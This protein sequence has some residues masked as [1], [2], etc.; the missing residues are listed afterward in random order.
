MDHEALMRR[1]LTLAARGRGWVSPNPMVGAV[2]A[3]NGTVIGEGW[4]ERCGAPHA[5]RNALASCDDARGAALYVTLEPCC[6]HGR[7]PPCTDAIIE[8]GVGR[9]VVGSHDPNPKVDG[10]GIARLRAR[11]IEVITGVLEAECDALNEIFFHY[12]TARTPFAVMKYAMTADGRIATRTGVSQ[13]ITS[14]SARARV[15]GTR[16][17]LRGILVGIGTVLADDPLLTC[18]MQ[19]GRSPVRIVCDSALRLPP[20]SRLVQAAREYPTI[21]AT[22]SQD[23]GRIRALED[24]GVTVLPVAAHSGRVDLRDLMQRLGA[25]EIDSLLVEGGAALGWSALDQGIVKRLQVYVG[26]K[27]FG[28]ADAP[29]PIGGAGVAQVS[30]AYPLRLRG[31]EQIGEDVL[32]EYDLEGI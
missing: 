17:A 2:L 23:G 5:E 20:S 25:R 11:G 24:A 32:L 8:S 18:R 30:E 31:V 10:G 27:L 13:W 3:R 29:G 7:T 28:G 16:H 12:I 4:H 6:H 19:G 14:D 21:V 26:A 15:H 1:A 22:L 9:V